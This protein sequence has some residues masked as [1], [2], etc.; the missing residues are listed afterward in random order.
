MENEVHPFRGLQWKN[1]T[2]TL[3][4]KHF[5]VQVRY[6]KTENMVYAWTTPKFR[7][8]GKFGYKLKIVTSAHDLIHDAV[9]LEIIVKSHCQFRVTNRSVTLERLEGY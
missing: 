4:D 7:I 5:L 1:V 8:A 2:V 6:H 3:V 9:V